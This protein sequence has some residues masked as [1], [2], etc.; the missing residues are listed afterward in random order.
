MAVEEVQEVKDLAERSLQASEKQQ[1]KEAAKE[2]CQAQRKAW[3]QKGHLR[4][5]V[6]GQS[7]AAA[8]AEGKAEPKPKPE[9][10]A[11]PK[12]QSEPVHAGTDSWG[13]RTLTKGSEKGKGKG[14]E[15]SSS[16]TTSSSS[17]TPSTSPEPSSAPDWDRSSDD[18]MK[19]N[20]LDKRSKKAKQTF[21]PLPERVAVDWFKTIEMKD[22]YL[23]TRALELL[24]DSGV[25]VR[26]LSYAGKQ[27]RREVQ[28]KTDWMWD[29]GLLNH[30][31]FT[32]KPTGPQG[33]K[34]ELIQWGV[35]VM[36]DDNED[37]ICECEEA[38][39]STYPI[40]SHHG[41]GGFRPL[42]DAVCHFLAQHGA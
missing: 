28:E 33:K 15:P 17:T 25:K 31:S 14:D 5:E 6:K 9:P 36:F 16:T 12:G 4:W 30:L 11:L 34:E 23:H 8:A 27:R 19:D 35:E 42:E 10:K 18:P 22:G 29:E 38:G 21:P 40:G 13:R 37:I 20:D 24:R 32:W 7:G 3:D 26:I 39:I 41:R 2:A 1:A